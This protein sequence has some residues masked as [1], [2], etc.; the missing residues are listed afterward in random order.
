MS[1][2]L[3][4]NC[5][6]C[7]KIIS[8]KN[9]NNFNYANKNNTDCSK[10]HCSGPI[11]NNQRCCSNCKTYKPMNYYKKNSG[12]C[13]TC[14][15]IKA[16]IY[17]SNPKI[18]KKL[19]EKANTSKAIAKRKLY[20]LNNEQQLKI[21]RA[22]R[23]KERMKNDINYRIKMS[24]R[25]RINKILDKLQLNKP[26]SIVES[27]NC[28]QKELMKHIESFFYP[29]P[30]TNEQ[31]SWKNYGLKGW[32][33]DHIIPLA[34]FNLSNKEEYLKACH[35]TNLQPLWAIDNLKKGKKII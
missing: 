6:K 32:H 34:S 5:P 23:H 17:N 7:N 25:G 8:Y 24:I 21:N 18:R 27:L 2:N 11:I 19:I 10:G 33:I 16:V 28:E 26:L 12:Q 35:Y 29:H 31:M 9:K 1:N 14:R 15:N 20:L 30:I 4:R 22:I 13:R 3:S